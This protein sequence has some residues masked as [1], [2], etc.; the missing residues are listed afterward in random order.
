[1]DANGTPPAGGMAGLSASDWR[2]NIL[3]H[4]PGA[5]AARPWICRGFERPL[6]VVLPNSRFVRDFDADADSIRGYA[7]LPRISSL[8]EIA[9]T[10]LR[11]DPRAAEAAGAAR[12]EAMARGTDASALGPRRP[13]PKSSFIAPDA[14]RNLTKPRSADSLRAIELREKP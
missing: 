10:S 11:D 4:L 1:M 7:D 9:I 6:L 8:P 3:L 2:G 14:A 13:V 12:G 5:G